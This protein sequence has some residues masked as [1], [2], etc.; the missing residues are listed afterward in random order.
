MCA[1]ARLLLFCPRYKAAI[2]HVDTTLIRILDGTRA[3]LHAMIDNFSRRIL[4]WKV[5]SK[6]DPSITA[7][8]LLHAASDL[9]DA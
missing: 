4:A 5:S 1:P 7:E 3:Y 6:F 8:L 2:C 9:V